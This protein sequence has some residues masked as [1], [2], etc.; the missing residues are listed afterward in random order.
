MENLLYLVE[1]PGKNPEPLVVS[2]NTVGFGNGEVA[3]WKHQDDADDLL[4]AA[5]APGRWVSVKLG[6]PKPPAPK[7]QENPRG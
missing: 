6:V 3:F 4:I 2:C 5:F 7:P 1:L